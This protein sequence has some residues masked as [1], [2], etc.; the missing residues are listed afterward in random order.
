[1]LDQ[2]LLKLVG[3]VV[4]D[5]TKLEIDGFVPFLVR[6]PLTSEFL[7]LKLAAAERTTSK[8]LCD[9]VVLVL[10]KGKHRLTLAVLSSG[11]INS[12]SSTVLESDADD[13]VDALGDWRSCV[14]RGVAV[15]KNSRVEHAHVNFFDLSG[16]AY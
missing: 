2:P 4:Q 6:V 1:M 3:H 5:G 10:V 7:Q 9:E 15:E 8:N 13:V 14:L 16:V 11:R 12:P